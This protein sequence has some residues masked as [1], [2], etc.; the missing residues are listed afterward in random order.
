MRRSRV[1]APAVVTAVFALACKDASSVTAPAPTTGTLKVGV[2]SPSCD[3]EGAFDVEVFID[4]VKVGTPTLSAT[5]LASYS[6]TAGSHT[7]GGFS[8]NGHWNWGSIDVTVPAGG[9]YTAV[10]ACR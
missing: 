3:S 10:F 9:S 2:E 8:V 5:A 7:L 4:H 1:L 6:V